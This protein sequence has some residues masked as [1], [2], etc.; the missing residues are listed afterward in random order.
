MMKDL[1]SWLQVVGV[2][3]IIELVDLANQMKLSRL[4]LP[5]SSTVIVRVISNLHL[6]AYDFE[7]MHLL[8]TT[9]W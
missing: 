5:F 6:F 7:M 9:F 8:T 4:Y 2:W 3:G 1:Y